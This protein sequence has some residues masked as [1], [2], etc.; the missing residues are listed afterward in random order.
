[1]YSRETGARWQARP[2]GTVLDV[3]KDK[4]E[5]D[6][7]DKFSTLT[8]HIPFKAQKSLNFQGTY[9]FKWPL[10]WICPH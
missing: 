9:P 6:P 5:F 3:H 2:Y 4:S 1:M 8:E 7:I 10:K